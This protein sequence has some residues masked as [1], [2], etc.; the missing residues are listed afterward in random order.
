VSSQDAQ[1]AER[2]LEALDP[3]QRSVAQFVSGPMAV[4]AGAGTGKTRAIT[5]R[6][7]YGV[8]RGV[9]EPTNVLAVTFTKRAAV[10]MRERQGGT[11]SSSPWKSAVYLV[12]SFF[13]FGMSMT[14][15]KT[16]VGSK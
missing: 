1:R 15:Q 12:R 14:R 16:N 11:P 7:A 2:L 13:S 5:Y 3:D 9:Y 8:A 4:L 6:I 10:E